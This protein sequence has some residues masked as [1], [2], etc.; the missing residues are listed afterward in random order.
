VTRPVLAL[1]TS[2]A[3]SVAVHDGT[4]VVAARH[5]HDPRRHAELL[6]PMVQ[7]VLDESR[8]D[9][10]DL[11]AVAV[12][13][14]P[15]PFT[16]LRVGLVTARTLSLALGVPVHGVPSLDALALQVAA[17]RVVP[18]GTD[19]VVATDARR[20][21]VYWGRYLV[22]AGPD[23]RRLSGPAVDRPAEVPVGGAPCFGR[24]AAVHPGVLPGPAEALRDDLLDASA[25]AVATLAVR[26]LAAGLPGPDEPLYLRRPDAVEPGPRR[27]ATP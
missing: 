24:G 14:G 19:M 23:A 26:R 11:A 3:V 8:I 20:R 2:G 16:G 10:H 1:D 22:L 17:G 21:E 13:T 18:P 25:T 4:A 9:R 6:V 15:G 27:R 7:E 5:V 12:G